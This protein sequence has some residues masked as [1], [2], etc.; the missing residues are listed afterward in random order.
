MAANGESNGSGDDDARQ[1]EP[2]IGEVPAT[3]YELSESCR[4]FAFS[5]IGV[6]LD[7]EP[8]TLPVLDEYLRV[9]SRGVSDRPELEP[10]VARAAGAYFGEVL[11]RRVDG[12][13]RHRP[14]LPDD[15]WELCSRRTLLSL[16]PLGLVLECLARSPD[17]AGPSGELRLAP[18]DA[19]LAE[20]RLALVPPVSEDEYYLLSTRLEVIETVY[21]T[22][23]DRMKVEGRE[24]LVFDEDD[25]SDE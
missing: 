17:H 14:N 16:S 11:R 23:R 22:L 24:S 5:A 1:E 4:R 15:E 20:E 10:L 25:Y 21:E 7:Y 19:A 8:E 13:W 9:A 18:D 3:I 6:E 12:F 2:V